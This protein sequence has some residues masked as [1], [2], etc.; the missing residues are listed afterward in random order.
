MRLL[1]SPMILHILKVRCFIFL[2]GFYTVYYGMASL[3]DRAQYAED[4]NKFRK[5]NCNRS[6]EF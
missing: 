1:V 2:E 5:N 4:C 6:S 3:N